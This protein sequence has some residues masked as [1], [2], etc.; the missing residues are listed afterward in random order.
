[1]NIKK[2]F[3]LLGLICMSFPVI[4]AYVTYHMAR[5]IDPAAS[6]NNIM[7]FMLPIVGI[8]ILL[9]IGVWYMDVKIITDIE[10]DRIDRNTEMFDKMSEINGVK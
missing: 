7:T 1:M 10:N 2:H 4:A 3:S 9:G 8:F 6:P 5:A